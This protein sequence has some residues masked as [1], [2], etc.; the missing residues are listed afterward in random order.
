MNYQPQIEWFKVHLG[1]LQ[2]ELDVA[3]VI[4]MFFFF[5]HYFDIFKAAYHLSQDRRCLSM[6]MSIFERILFFIL[7]LRSHT[8]Q[9]RLSPKGCW[10]WTC[11]FFLST[12]MYTIQTCVFTSIKSIQIKSDKETDLALSFHPSSEKT[13]FPQGCGAKFSLGGGLYQHH[14]DGHG[15]ITN[16]PFGK[17]WGRCWEAQNFRKQLKW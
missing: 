8:S 5:A 16:G 9:L 6:L 1:G 10:C 13:V 7:R 2:L 17:P 3:K 15:C 11:V 4:Q 12:S 14:Q